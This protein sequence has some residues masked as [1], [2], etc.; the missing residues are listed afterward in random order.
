MTSAEGSP[1]GREG[2]EGSHGREAS[3]N[4]RQKLADT[5]EELL[6][7][8]DTTAS[9]MSPADAQAY[10]RK[11]ENA[12]AA[13]AVL[14]Q[15]C[16]CETLR[17]ILAEGSPTGRDR[18]KLTEIVQEALR[19]GASFVTPGGLKYWPALDAF[20]ELLAVL[21]AEYVKAIEGHWSNVGSGPEWIEGEG[22]YGCY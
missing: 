2:S 3:Y 11:V 10:E 20:R 8:G 7:S 4:E 19:Q 16:Q 18:Q 9:R 14:A 22:G 17:Q 12:R 15:P 1:S 5:V 6:P 13:L 21:D